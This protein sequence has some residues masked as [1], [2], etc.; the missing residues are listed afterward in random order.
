MYSQGICASSMHTQA[1]AGA[2]QGTSCVCLQINLMRWRTRRQLALISRQHIVMINTYHYQP[3]CVCVCVQ[4]L[5]LRDSFQF[6]L[7]W[8]FFHS[9]LILLLVSFLISSHKMAAIYFPFPLYSA[10]DFCC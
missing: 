5:K 1:V 7:P 10:H 9:F 6:V 4:L 3:Q 8:V 2:P